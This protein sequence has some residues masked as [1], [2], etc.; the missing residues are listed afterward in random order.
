L[1]SE[2]VVSYLIDQGLCD[3]RLSSAEVR[4]LSSKN[5]NLLVK[6]PN[7]SAFLVKQERFNTREKTYGEFRKEWRIQ[8]LLHAFPQLKSLSPLMS[9]AVHFDSEHSIIVMRYFEECSDCNAFYQEADQFPPAVAAVIGAA[10]AEVH[11]ATYQR[12]EY[13][14]FL[15]NGQSSNGQSTVTLERI[16]KF[17]QPFH[18]I[19]PG[20]FG[21]F[22]SDGI[23]FFR[24]FQRSPRLLAAIELLQDRWQSTCLIHNDFRFYNILLH[25]DWETLLP[26]QQQNA[27]VIRIIDWERCRWGDPAFDLAWLIADYLTLWMNSL[28]IHPAV[29]LTTALQLAQT[30]LERLQPTL[31]ALVQGYLSRFPQITLSRP[32]FLPHVME[33]T[34]YYLI[35]KLRRAIE[36]HRPFDNQGICTMQ[37]AKKLLCQPEDALIS[38]FG[39]S[40][41]SL[42][43]QLMLCQKVSA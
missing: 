37:V 13:L 24:L 21:A 15:S 14:N 2:N 5:F 3:S 7:Q 31:L 19:N 38:I 16:P 20:I 43:A 33:Y 22:C 42:L 29:D 12:T 9:E 4:S 32:E 35:S 26:D 41:Q 18:K 27:A 36:E 25:R 23:E 17:S 6:F 11:A 30:P 8:E 39:Q 1:S 34:G 40:A 10:L 28:M